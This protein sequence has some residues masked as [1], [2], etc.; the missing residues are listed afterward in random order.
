MLPARGACAAGTDGAGRDS[1]ALDLRLE[2]GDP[3]V[4]TKLVATSVLVAA[5]T[6][7]FLLLERAFAAASDRLGT[8]TIRAEK[9]LPPSLDVFG[10]APRPRVPRLRAPGLGN[11]TEWRAG[12][13]AAGGAR[14]T[15][16][17]PQWSRA[18]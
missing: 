11:A 7:P 4:R 5:G 8:F 10:C 2:S 17:T 3:E 12:G 14:G 9:T 13:P 15:P 1:G 6:D 16:S 18:G